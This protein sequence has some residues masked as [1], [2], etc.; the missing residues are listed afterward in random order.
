M[1]LRWVT[2]ETATTHIGSTVA[3]DKAPR[4]PTPG[5]GVR[6]IRAGDDSV[7]FD[8]DRPGSPV[9]VKASYFPNWK[10]NGAKGPWRV[11]PNLMVVVP[12][13]RH[14]ELRYG[15]TP[16]DVAGWL[17]TFAGVAGVVQFARR[18]RVELE[19]LEA[20]PDT[21]HDRPETEFAGAVRSGVSRRQ[22]VPAPDRRT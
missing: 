7:S 11:T 9:L 15:Y 14:V 18:G 5:T 10:A 4:R 1:T 3:V 8:V 17:L 13:S 19:P 20:P 22:P 2:P 6:N 12:T 16:V 21:V